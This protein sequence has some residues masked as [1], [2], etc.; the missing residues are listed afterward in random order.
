MDKKGIT[1]VELL[2]AIVLFG[3][4][5]ALV[6]TILTTIIRANKDI[7]IST[8]ANSEGN[9][10]I[11]ILENELSK[12]ELTNEPTSC[13]PN[14]I[15]L[16]SSERYVFED[17]SVVLDSTE[18]SLQISFISNSIQ[19]IK[20]ENGLVVK[21]QSYPID[22][23]TLGSGSSIEWTVTTV[24]YRIQITIELLDENGKSYIYLASHIY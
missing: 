21:N 5:A 16:I 23:F 8:Q 13:G 15:L 2:A 14:C 22:Y 18:H 7:Q 24:S 4:V 12:F 10:L 1:L 3:I 20:I 6:S 17:G 11:T 19:I 9:Y